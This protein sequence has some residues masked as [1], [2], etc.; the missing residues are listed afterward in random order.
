[1]CTR[2]E[3]LSVR[4][5]DLL[6]RPRTVRR[7]GTMFVFPLFLRE[8]ALI[9][10]DPDGNKSSDRGGL[11]PLPLEIFPGLRSVNS[12]GHNSPSSGAIPPLAMATTGGGGSHIRMLDTPFPPFILSHS[13]QRHVAWVVLPWL[14]FRGS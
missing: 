6:R 8:V 1:M 14:G 5:H 9:L 11:W 4:A 10:E 12:I 2:R 3:G 13:G 7:P